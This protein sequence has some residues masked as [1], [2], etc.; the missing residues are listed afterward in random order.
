[1]K[2]TVRLAVAIGALMLLSTASFAEPSLVAKPA[3][4]VHKTKTP[5]AKKSPANKQLEALCRSLKDK[6][7][8]SAYAKLSALAS[9]KNPGAT[10]SRAALALG[11][12]DYGRGNFSDAE[13]WLLLA[14]NDPLLRDYTTYWL[15]ETRFAMGRSLDALGD[16]KQFRTQFPDSVMTDQAM[17][18]LAE[19]ANA[20][21]QS[22]DLIAAL[23][24][25]PP[26]HDEPNLLF[27]RAGARE[28]AG[29]P[30]A[31]VA[32]YLQLYTRFPLSQQGR[33]AITHLAF[34]ASTLG[35]QMPPIPL[36]QRIAHADTFFGSRNWSEAR[37]EY[38]QLLPQL[39]GTDLERAQMRIL[40]C[41]LSLGAAPSELEALQITDPDVNAERFL[42]LAQFYRSSQ[43]ETQMVAA[44]ESAASRAPGSKWTE[45][46]L[47]LG[48]NY[49]WTLLNRDAASGFYKRVEENFPASIDALAAHW[50]VT[51]TAVLE[52]RDNAAAM[53]I[54]HLNR[55]PG[56]EYT[57]DAVYWLGRLAE[58]AN[59]TIL[60]RSY[61]DKLTE[62]FP[63]SYFTGVAASRLRN[64][65][66][67]ATQDPEELNKI[68]PAPVIPKL[69]DVVPALAAERQARADALTSIAF[70]SSA[71]ME[72]RAGYAASHEP[73][74][75]LEAAQASI[76]G[77]HYGAAIVTVRQVYPQLDTHQIADVPRDV[78]LAA[79]ALPYD[80]SIRSWSAKMKLDP[81]LVAGLIHQESAFSAEARS[82]S[83]AL[84]M[85]QLISE[86]ARR[87]A[88]QAGVHYSQSR[89]FDPDYNIH[90]GTVYLADLR[91][92]FDSVEMALAA[93]NAGENRV[94]QWLTGQ[95][96]REPAEFVDSIP[97]TQTRDYVEIITRNADI[98]RKLYG[99]NNESRQPAPRPKH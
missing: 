85:M 23:D 94:T 29:Q 40:A 84:G 14:K 35:D 98:Y 37:G 80:Q 68:P 17:Q 2:F 22:A 13:K 78:W 25:Y 49:Y 69:A 65:G 7:F 72:L 52:R 79:Y 21:S 4:K 86:T 56:S 48:G 30:L 82:T 8:A 81:M 36:G 59:N 71:E 70:D 46:A 89:L 10:G 39:S 76:A 88:K 99:E 26:T 18:A 34:L 16:L 15:A 62:R 58:E 61:Y 96:Y 91:E 3:A 54:E 45:Q 63:Q 97:F 27:A 50:R 33:Q 19:A 77:G 74:F 95:T 66:T 90:L 42:S 32:D 41:G 75:L 38:S 55:F 44:I 6:N 9:Q 64:L 5:P 73:R 83:N 20:S 57:P 1:M 24:A 28:K 67:G 92:Q 12:F 51:W 43:Q 31:A 93:Y 60:A 87:M 11:Y 53:L 47:F